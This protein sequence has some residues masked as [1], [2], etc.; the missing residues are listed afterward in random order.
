MRT[1]LHIILF[2]AAILWYRFS[3]AQDATFTFQVSSLQTYTVTF[4][5]TGHVMADTLSYTFTW[6]F[7][8][9]NTGSYPFIQHRYAAA[10]TYTVTLSVQDNNTLATDSYSLAVSITDEFAV[11]NVFTPDGD[12][13]NDQFIIQS[14]GFTPLTVTIFNRAGSVVFKRT[15][16]T[17]VWDGRTPSGER[18]RPGVYYFVITS[19][20]PLYNKTGFVHLFYGK[21]S[22]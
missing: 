4:T 9:G 2:S 18:A 10:G 5:A 17:V 3:I 1:T 14:N 19:D 8:D 13:I 20:D 12:G 16:P 11:P 15:A 6:D 7:D 21:D 22:R